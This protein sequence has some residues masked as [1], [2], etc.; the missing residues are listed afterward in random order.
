MP[1]TEATHYLIKCRSV[2]TSCKRVRD[3][4]G[5]ILLQK[6]DSFYHIYQKSADGSLVFYTVRDHLMFFMVYCLA[7]RKHG[8]EVIG[9]CQMPDHTHGLIRRVPAPV[10]SAFV[11]DYT[12][13]FSATY[14][15]WYG[16][17]GSLFSHGFGRALKSGDK[18]V[19]T[20]TAYLYNNPVEKWICKKAPEYQWNY[21]AYYESSFPF[22]EKIVFHNARL[23]L[24]NAI[25]TVRFEYNSGRVVSYQ[26]MD[27]FL[28]ELRREEINYLIDYIIKT[29]NCI[30]Y[31][32][33]LSRY[34][35]YDSMIKA[36]STL[37]VKEHDIKEEF[38]PGSD[39]AY[40]RI[41]KCLNNLLPNM[42]IREILTLPVE[43]RELLF[44]KV[45][46]LSKASE[47]QVAKFLQLTGRTAGK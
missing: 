22:S 34:E 30:D 1:R 47:R 14:N 38:T 20:A 37:T 6:D 28:K 5:R 8:V 40:A 4:Q 27:V 19:R 7:A 26:M 21:L 35:S 24:R 15:A 23:A 9:L 29:Y 46:W 41:H 11:S 36:F 17:S 13:V 16:R 39:R 3:M 25:R 2:L 32:S 12:R 31:Q 10:L 45:Q 44:K 43:Q 33:L 18:A 42:C